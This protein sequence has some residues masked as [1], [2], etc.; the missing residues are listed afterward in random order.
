[1]ARNTYILGT[2]EIAKTT[3]GGLIFSDVTPPGVAN[4]L[5]RLHA[6]DE[7]TVVCV[8][9]NGQLYRT[10]DAGVTWSVIAYPGTG[11][12]NLEDLYFIG[13]DG[14]IVGSSGKMIVSADGGLTWLNTATSPTVQ[15]ILCVHMMDAS[16]LVVGDSAGDVF[17]SSDGGATWSADIGGATI[18]ANPIVDVYMAT[19]S[20]IYVF[21]ASKYFRTNDGGATWPITGF[22][23][24]GVDHVDFV[25]DNVG[26]VTGVNNMRFVTTDGATTF[27]DLNPSLSPAS[28]RSAVFFN[29]LGVG[30]FGYTEGVYKSIDS[31]VTLSLVHT[32]GDAIK[33]IYS[34]GDDVCGCT[35]PS[36]PNYDP[37][38]TVDDGSC[39]SECCDME[40]V[41]KD[42]DCSPDCYSPNSF[43]NI[44]YT[45]I[46]VAPTFPILINTNVVEDSTGTV[47][48]DIDDS[49]P[50]QA[51]LDLL[52]N[53]VM[54]VNP[55][56]YTV[57][58][59]VDGCVEATIKYQV[60]EPLGVYKND[61]NDY[62]IHRPSTVTTSELLVTVSELE[63][64]TLID[65]ATWSMT[66]YTYG[67]TV[68][69]DGIYII[70]LHEPGTP[71]VLIHSFAIFEVC[72]LLSCIRAITEIMLCEDDDPCCISCDED[73]VKL[74]KFATGQANKLIPL[75]YTYI[76]IAKQY[77]LHN[78]G[79]S[80][81]DDEQ[82]NYLSEAKSIIDK[83]NLLTKDCSGL[84][85][86][87]SLGSGTRTGCTNC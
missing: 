73:N 3:D 25:D 33:D 24:D 45:G 55:G 67:F 17:V 64:D 43:I 10:D 40:V 37:I 59:T 53:A 54:L 9:D 32:M 35:D 84:C 44:K 85:Q 83:I 80:L 56:S 15:N 79:S 49:V 63:G 74:R 68:P 72:K 14:F 50:D 77:K 27:T 61:C 12:E 6:I 41:I 51:T 22:L 13:D 21:N 16:N 69:G 78:I 30:F 76:G 46:L 5:N 19:A 81:L 57:T 75:Y 8:G 7:N 70:E 29:D 62:Y 52:T 1:M 34:A 82:L 4:D 26:Y 71:S 58:I 2:R 65:Q 87:L 47:V 66:D 11:S 60:C 23:A 18:P 42:N 20:S 28:D 86:Q 48:A 39:E 31:G 38:A 36:S